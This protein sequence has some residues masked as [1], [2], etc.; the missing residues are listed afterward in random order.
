MAMNITDYE[1]KRVFHY[2]NEVTKIPRGSYNTDAISN[3]LV[4]VGKDLGLETIQDEVGNVIIKVPATE[5]YEDAAPV[6]LQGHMDIVCTVAPGYDIDMTKE[7][8]KLMIDGDWLTADG[9]TLGG[10]NGIALAMMLALAEAKDIPHPALELVSTVD[11]ETGLEGAEAIDASQLKARKMI[12]LDSE[13]EGIITVS[14]AGGITGKVHLPVR[15]QEA[16]GGCFHLKMTGLAGGH[17]GSDIHKELGNANMLMGRALYDLSKKVDFC[18]S[19]LEGGHLDNVICMECEAEI[20]VPGASAADVKSEIAAIEAVLQAEYKT[21]DPGVR[22]EV[23]EL[24]EGTRQAIDADSTKRTLLYLLNAPY[25]VQN[26]SMDIPGLVETSLNLGALKLEEEEVFGLYALR[27][28]LL[29]RMKYLQ[30]RLSTI[31]ELC[32]GKVEYSLY[33]PAWEFRKDSPLRDTCVKV[34]EKMYGREPEVEAI[35]AGLECGLFA[36]KMC[37]DFDA[38][39]IGPD[40]ECVHTSDERLSIPSTARTWEYLVEILKECK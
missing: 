30:D 31:V 2:F 25:G 22:I 17:S 6:L 32:G 18:I 36:G 5:G 29:T 16:K 3:Y 7:A 35:H 24:G 1:P 27:S 26:M 37:E 19:Q 28:S 33:Y 12:N 39:S 4:S 14:C 38:V 8:P 9:T 11:E 21:S 13:E 40:M 34:F 15:R 20:V 23:E 10:D